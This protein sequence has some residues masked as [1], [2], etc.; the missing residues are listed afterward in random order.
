MTEI[1]PPICKNCGWF[2]VKDHSNYHWI[3][4]EC[5]KMFPKAKYT[6]QKHKVKP[7]K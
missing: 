3:C 1:R 7:K 5:G 4:T 2:N 6:V